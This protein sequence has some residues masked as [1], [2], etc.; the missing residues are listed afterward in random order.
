MSRNRLTILKNEPDKELYQTRARIILPILV[1]QAVAGEKITYAD[2]GEELDLHHRVIKRPL[3]CIGDTLLKLGEQWQEKIPHIQGLVVNKQTNLPG[4]NVNFLRPFIGRK[5]DPRQKEA[6]VEAVLGKVFSYP[7]WL[8][9]LQELRLPPA[10]QPN[11]QLLRRA[12]HRDRS[13]ES[14]SHKRLK[15]YVARHPESVKLGKSLAPG[16]KEFRL[17]SGDK[18]DVLFQNTKRRIAVEVK[19]HISNKADLMRG[20]FQCI[21]YRAILRACR[22]LEGGTYEADALLAIEGQLPK[23]F[24]PVRNTLGVKVIEN[25]RIK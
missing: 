17:A 11:L 18:I 16:K 1:R 6:I 8:S 19:S 24:I 15:D 22:S 5:I 12:A 4:D 14:E 2:L 13:S 3:G 20:L 23:E 25:I 21:K 7:K 9:V 10:E